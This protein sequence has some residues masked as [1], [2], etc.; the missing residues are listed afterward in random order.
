MAEAGCVFLFVTTVANE[1][2]AEKLISTLI[3]EQLAA[4]VS[5]TK[6]TSHYIWQGKLEETEELQLQIK[7]SHSTC[8]RLMER[9]SEIH[10]YDTPEIMCFK[11]T[12]ANSK[13]VSWV[14]AACS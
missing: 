8:Q 11:S 5:V 6:V 10:P 9:I 14:N 1:E 3:A 4:C 12:A 7:T 13:Y 2:Q